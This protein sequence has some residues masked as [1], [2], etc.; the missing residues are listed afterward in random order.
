MNAPQ[1]KFEGTRDGFDIPVAAM[2]VH[3]TRVRRV[4]GGPSGHRQEKE[5]SITLHCYLL[6]GAK[7]RLVA[8]VSTAL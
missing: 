3:V 5:N 6:I 1:I 7:L 8:Q 2:E 4:C